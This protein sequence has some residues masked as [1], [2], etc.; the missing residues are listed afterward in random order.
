MVSVRHNYEGKKLI[1]PQIRHYGFEDDAQTH[2]NLGT[3]VQF[4][5][6]PAHNHTFYA[7]RMVLG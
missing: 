5:N 3:E 2:K 4:H 7:M 1:K 6:C